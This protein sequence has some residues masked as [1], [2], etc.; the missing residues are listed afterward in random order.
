MH[1]QP[2]PQTRTYDAFVSHAS[3][4]SKLATRLVRSLEGAGLKIWFD[5]SELNYSKLLRNQIQS[6]IGDSGGLVLIWSEHANRS[7][8]VMAELF[9]AF[10]LGRLIVPCILDDTP[11]PHFLQNGA[12]LDSRRYKR[13]VTEKLLRTLPHLPAAANDVIVLP[14]NQ[15]PV[16]A[17]LI[18]A[19]GAGQYVVLAGLDRDFQKAADANAKLRSSLKSVQKL[20]PLDREVLALAGYQCKNDYIIK[21]WKKIEQWIF[22]KDRLL[23]RGERYFF[24]TLCFNPKEADAINGLGS[25]LFYELELDAAEFFQRRAIELMR[26]AGASYYAAEHDLE[27]ILKLKQQQP[28]AQPSATKA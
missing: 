6:A 17:G 26:A 8:W 2:A 25:I 11:L 14:G 23:A 12:F 1:P 27:M 7:R 24:D 19:I 9:T 18:R 20:A 21:H 28:G 15:N 5:D 10:H 16:I 13:K 22:P 4:D 3:E